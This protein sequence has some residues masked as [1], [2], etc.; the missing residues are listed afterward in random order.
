MSMHASCLLVRIYMLYVWSALWFCVHQHACIHMSNVCTFVCVWVCACVWVLCSGCMMML[1]VDESPSLHH[2]ISWITAPLHGQSCN[3]Q[4][5]SPLLPYLIP[6]SLT[7]S[8][9]ASAQPWATFFLTLSSGTLCHF[10]SPLFIL[11]CNL[12]FHFYFSTALNSFQPH[13]SEIMSFCFCASLSQS[14][15]TH[16]WGWITEPSLCGSPCQ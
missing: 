14:Q 13:V 10:F 4:P 11:T 9:P 3:H 6:H 16:P 8:L 15:F 2:V 5:L 7:P 12:S 1:V